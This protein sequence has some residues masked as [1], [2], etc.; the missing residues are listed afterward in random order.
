MRKRTIVMLTALCLVLS[1]GSC[2][3]KAASVQEDNTGAA[4]Q[5]S[6]VLS[7][8]IARTDIHED[9]PGTSLRLW[10]TIRN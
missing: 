2:G 4:Y 6:T 9:I 7:S 1:A 3:G 8:D 5:G 10:S